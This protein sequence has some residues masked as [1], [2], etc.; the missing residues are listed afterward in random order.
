MGTGQT[1]SIRRQGVHDR[2]QLRVFATHGVSFCKRQGRLDLDSRASARRKRTY[3]VFFGLVLL[4]LWTTI[5]TNPVI[6]IRASDQRYPQSSI[7]RRSVR[8]SRGARIMPQSH[9]RSVNTPMNTFRNRPG[10]S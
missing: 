10:T 9:A 3:L 2:E 8:T 1:G 6:F 7:G 5:A 4:W